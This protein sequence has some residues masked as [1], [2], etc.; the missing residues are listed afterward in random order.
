MEQENE[1][2]KDFND[3]DMYYNVK[4]IYYMENRNTN[5]HSE[6]EKRTQVY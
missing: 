5:I 4:G 3:T 2:T 6:M 1:K